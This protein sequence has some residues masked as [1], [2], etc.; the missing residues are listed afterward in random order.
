[1]LSRLKT[2]HKRTLLI[3]GALWLTSLAFVAL[4]VV[5]PG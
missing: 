5:I 4:Q 1:M 2:R 3:F